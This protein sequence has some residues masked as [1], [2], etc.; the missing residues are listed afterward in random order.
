[1]VHG[2]IVFEQVFLRNSKETQHKSFLFVGILQ[3]HTGKDDPK[4][5]LPVCKVRT[6]SHRPIPLLR[7]NIPDLLSQITTTQ[8]VVNS[9]KAGTMMM[10]GAGAMMRV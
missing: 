1:M 9:L 10:M 2:N 3:A 4:K 8:Q 5:A 6:R 7:Q